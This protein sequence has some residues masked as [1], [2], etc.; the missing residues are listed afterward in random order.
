MPRSTTAS[1]IEKDRTASRGA[2]LHIAGMH[3]VIAWTP[4]LAARMQGV[5]ARVRRMGF[6]PAA[7]VVALVAAINF[8]ANLGYPP[9]PIWD[10]SYYLTAVAR[11]EAGIAQ[12]ASHPPLGLQFITAGDV[13]LHPNRGIDTRRMGW[14]KKIAGDK[15]PKGYSFAGVRLMPGVF[16]ALG[17]VAFFALIYVLTQSVLA[18]LAFSN[19]YVF[20]NAL[21]VHFRAA[22]LDPFQIAFVLGALLCF[23]V[24]ARRGG[25]SSP[26][27]ETAY[28][29]CVGF[30]CMAK[31][32]ACVLG[33]LGVMLIARRIVLG[34]RTRPRPRLLLAGARDGLLMAAGCIAAIA[35][36]ATLHVALNRQPPIAAS[37]AGRK[38][39]T[40]ITATYAEYLHR[41]RL[42]SPAVVLD[43]SRDYLRFMF[44][45]LRGVPRTDPNG[46]KPL[47]W[48][49]H[50]GTINYRWDSTGERTAYV[51]LT[52]NPAG[53]LLGLVALVAS[54]GLVLT[55]AWQRMRHLGAARRQGEPAAPPGDPA[56]R[57]IIVMLLV[58]YVVYMAVHAYIGMERVMYLYHYFTALLISYSLVPLVLAEA[59]DR[60]PAL[61]ARQVPILAGMVVLLWA[62]FIFYAPLTFHWYL[63]V[64]QCEWRNVLQHVVACHH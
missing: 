22:Q 36:V 62:G 7:A 40:F 16:G 43:A 8:L 41:E 59:A 64:Q 55:W 50:Q 23:A 10:E 21:I 4:F 61:R 13:L 12:F 24:S 45:D 20:E 30:A 2:P 26:G 52:G 53:W 39:L 25:R 35:I 63:T 6:A 27:I 11:Y 28:G 31:L 48:P 33:A 5:S 56:R 14:D 32:N 44:D 57:A 51:Q 60:W 29:L 9:D 34:W 3:R 58:Q 46:S 1:D 38:D 54:V 17:A 49:L 15:I 37:P 18:A 42:L 47:T 19:L